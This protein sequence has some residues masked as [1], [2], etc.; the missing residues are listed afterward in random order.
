MSWRTDLLTAALGTVLML[1]SAAAAQEHHRDRQCAERIRRVEWQLRRD[2]ER[3]GY[4]SP[5]ARHRRAEI[6]RLRERCG[7]RHN[8][9]RDF[10]DDRNDRRP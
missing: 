7:F 6:R 10:G 4:Y 1:G 8:R 2:I 5:Q 9:R 3:H